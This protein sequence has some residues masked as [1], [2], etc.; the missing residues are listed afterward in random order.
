MKSTLP[1]LLSATLT[2]PVF[3][4]P[5]ATTDAAPQKIE[6]EFMT[7]EDFGGRN[8]EG[9]KFHWVRMNEA[10]FK[11]G[12]ISGA[13][14]TQCDLSNSDLRGAKLGDNTTFTQVLMND[15]NLEGLDLMGADFDKVNLRGAN[16]QGTKNFGKVSKTTFDGA[17]LRGADL[18]SIPTPLVEVTFDKAIYDEKTRFPEGVDPTAAGAIK[19]S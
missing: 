14:F 13:T 11:D 8:L 18:S 3:A 7:E 15:A 5:A 9:T 16:L 6:R 10:T 2:L 12:L 1:L 17:D 4:E 19:K